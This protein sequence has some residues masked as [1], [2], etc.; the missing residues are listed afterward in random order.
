MASVQHDC[1][2][3]LRNVDLKVTP[4][5]LGVLAA[6]EASNLPIDISAVAQYLK[7]HRIKADKVTIFRVMNVLTKKG[8]AN[9]IELNEGKFR[10]EYS[11]KADHHHFICENC[12][13]IEDVSDCNIK[14]LEKDISKKKGFLVKRHSLEFFGICKKCQQLP[15]HQSI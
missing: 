15:P 7:I 12:S 3:E 6:L 9:P 5:R 14:E 4:A 11:A 8:L 13:T 1:K 10:Y 2:K